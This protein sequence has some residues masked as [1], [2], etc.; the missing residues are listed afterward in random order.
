MN[1]PALVTIG[2]SLA[3]TVNDFVEVIFDNDDTNIPIPALARKVDD[4]TDGEGITYSVVE[5]TP[6][7]VAGCIKN[8]NINLTDEEFYVFGQVLDF[9]RRNAIKL[10]EHWVNRAREDYKIRLGIKKKIGV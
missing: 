3:I 4:Y 8:I 2:T 1:N 5:I 9:L 6:M 10:S 7:F